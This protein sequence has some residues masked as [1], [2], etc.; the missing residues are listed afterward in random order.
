HA[1]MTLT[2]LAETENDASASEGFVDLMAL[3]KGADII[4]LFKEAEPKRIRISVRTSERV[5]AVAITSQFGGGGHARAA[6]CTVEAELD[7]ARAQLLAVCERELARGHAG[8][9]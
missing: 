3:T 1:A 6:G 7:D 2:M 5:D 8:G 9:H 4:V